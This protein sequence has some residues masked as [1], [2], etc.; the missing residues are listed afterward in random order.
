M[1]AELAPI[2]VDIDRAIARVLDAG[3]FVG[4]P[5]VAGFEAELAVAANCRHALGTS[6]GT[7]A[8]LVALMALGV[9]PGD[10]VVTTPLTFFATAGAAVRLGARVVFAD[11][12]EATL[13]LDPAAAEAATSSK[14]RAIIV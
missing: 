3:V 8:L 9:G 7:D 4:G 10:E 1:V 14:T 6:S 12:D 13:C 5:E 11:I 2:R